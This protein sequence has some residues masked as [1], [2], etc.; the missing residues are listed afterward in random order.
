MSDLRDELLVFF[1][2]VWA[3]FFYVLIGIVAKFS[4]DLAQG[5]KISFLQAIGSVG[6]SLFI[7]FLAAVWCTNNN[8]SLAPY[9]VPIATLSADK[10]I[11]V[12][13]G[14]DWKE[15]IGYFIKK[16]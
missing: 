13:I 8:P 3:L 6:I 11:M 16:K 2:K 4:L 15:F 12:I 7:G 10:I 5:K 14:I 9:I 1:S